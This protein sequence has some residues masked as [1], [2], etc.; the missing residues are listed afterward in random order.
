MQHDERFNNLILVS[1]ILQ[2]YQH[3]IIK[4]SKNN[5]FYMYEKFLAINFWSPRTSVDISSP[6]SL[7][8]KSK[9]L[10]IV[11]IRLLCFIFM[12]RAA[13]TITL[14]K[15]MTKNII[16]EYFQFYGNPTP[17]HIG[18]LS[19]GICANLCAN[20]LQYMLFNGK[21]KIFRFL[22]KIKT[23]CLKYNLN[24]AS[25]R[26]FKI[27]LQVISFFCLQLSIYSILGIVYLSIGIIVVYLKEDYKLLGNYQITN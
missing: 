21:S 27:R 11:L 3:L 26:K 8:S 17:I 9:L 19:G 10:A 4:M 13:I 20:P 22:F 6:R 18:L 15:S 5:M 16:C 1:G 12:I 2:V 23:G 24:R 7:V 14:P 25:E